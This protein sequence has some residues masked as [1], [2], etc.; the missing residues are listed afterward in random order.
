MERAAYKS[1]AASSS[2]E[3]WYYVAGGKKNGPVAASKLTSM[4]A[5][6]AL[7]P[8]TRVWTAGMDQWRP[9]TDTELLNQVNHQTSSSV[10]V[11]LPSAE[12]P[13]P[14]R[15]SR[16]WIWL[17]I[18]ILVV[19]ILAAASYFLFFRKDA[20]DA[21]EN[22]VAEELAI[23]YGLEDPVVFDN[24]AC[25]F[26]IDA[27]GEKGDFLEL[28]V[29]CVNKTSDVLSFSWAST[30]I[31]GS[32]FDP[33]WCVYVQGNST[34]KSS[35]TFPLS[36]LE[37]YNLL[38]AEQIKFV[39]SVYNEDQFDRQREESA[40]YIMYD[41]GLLDEELYSNYKQIDGYSSYLFTRNVRV[42]RDGRP[43]YVN[44][45]RT[46]VYFDEICTS[47]GQ[48][49]YTQD[50]GES[51]YESFYN[52]RYG[53]PFYFSDNGTTIYY[54]GYGFAFTDEET[55]KNY[56]YDEN[57]KPAYYGNGGIPEYYEGTVPQEY[58]DAGMPESLANATSNCI[59]H[60]EFSIYPTGK[61]VDDITY[62]NRVSASTEQVYWEGEKG[63]FTV[64]GGEFDEF[65][66]YIV[67]TYV[68]NHSDSYIY[69]GWSSVVVN[70]V[71][72][73]PD[74]I[75][76]L[77]PHSNAYR[78]I[79]IPVDL[80]KENEIEN[81]EE[82]DFRVYAVGENLSVPLYPIAWEATTIAGLTK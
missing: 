8:D 52:D 50:P 71:I 13:S 62:P 27:I 28:D 65:K 58:L 76:E 80:L 15:K 81:V 35:I 10:V 56:F 2:S 18:G 36:T 46:T 77:R 24:A 64:L 29:R 11:N 12:Q 21:A 48:P 60:E 30:C 45:D 49:L 33:L 5:S 26:L 19:A 23:T 25:T 1:S 7:P 37:S 38:P 41:Y 68:E 75:T 82:I 47:S 16:W 55:G 20:P 31:N 79:I 69:F 74:S 39:L 3:T 17:I 9:A 34:M 63:S 42:T 6:G 54:D 78:D 70:G 73:Y 40:E 53:R 4:L 32:M 51:N 44:K 43:Y 22:A 14:K 59:V 67:H 61:D 66:G 57:G 72:A